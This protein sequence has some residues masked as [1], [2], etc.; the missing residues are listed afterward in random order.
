MSSPHPALRNPSFIVKILLYAAS[1]QPSAAIYL[2]K[3]LFIANT[4]S[5]WRETL[6]TVAKSVYLLFLIQRPNKFIVALRQ[7]VDNEIF[8]LI[9]CLVSTYLRASYQYPERH[10]FHELWFHASWDVPWMANARCFTD[11]LLTHQHQKNFE[12]LKILV[13]CCHRFDTQICPDPVRNPSNFVEKF[14]TDPALS[15]AIS[16]SS[17]STATSCGPPP[18][19]ARLLLQMQQHFQSRHQI[20]PVVIDFMRYVETNK[21]CPP[22]NIAKM[23]SGIAMWRNLNEEG[24]VVDG[25]PTHAKTS[26][27]HELLKTIVGKLLTTGKIF[28]AALVSS[29]FLMF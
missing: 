26:L 29:M 11:R 27:L 2:H 14:L 28:V 19:F 1:I 5:E 13:D 25:E 23:F 9:E 18:I 4:T 20:V 7:A 17:R 12:I 21:I 10:P 22:I 6:Q 8:W 15:A 24:E 3:A 16:N